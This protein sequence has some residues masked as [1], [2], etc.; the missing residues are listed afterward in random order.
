MSDPEELIGRTVEIMFSGVLIIGTVTAAV[1]AYGGQI[2]VR[3]LLTGTPYTVP[4]SAITE[5]S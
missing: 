5:W 2:T 3:S 4:V 1:P